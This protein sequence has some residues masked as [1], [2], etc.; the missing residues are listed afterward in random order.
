MECV[1]P[2][3]WWGDV[4]PMV[5]GDIAI[6][7]GAEDAPKA[8]DWVVVELEAWVHVGGNCGASEHE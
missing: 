6:V 2:L 1:L 3:W 5:V 7:F 4:G 8:C